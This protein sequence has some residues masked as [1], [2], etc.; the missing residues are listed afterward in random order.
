MVSVTPQGMGVAYSRRVRLS[1]EHYQRAAK[2]L[3]RRWLRGRS[4]VYAGP[5]E[6]QVERIPEN[7][8]WQVQI[9]W[10]WAELPAGRGLV[11]LKPEYQPGWT[12]NM[13][14]ACGEGFTAIEKPC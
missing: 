13:D 14:D 3:L 4:G 1:Q 2:R 5:H 10:D 11:A 8:C 9:Y 7:R 6:V 12:V